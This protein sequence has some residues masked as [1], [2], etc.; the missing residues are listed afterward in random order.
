MSNLDRII[1]D[2]I[3][4]ALEAGTVPW[5]RPWVAAGGEH[6]NPSSGTVYRGVN[7]LLLELSAMEHEFA[8]ARWL[9]MRQANALGGRV[10]K[11]SRST[12]VI[13]YKKRE[14]EDA[15][16]G[17]TRER[18]VM[19]HFTVFNVDQ[20]EGIDWPAPPSFQ[21][22]PV[23]RADELVRGYVETTGP[24][25]LHGAQSRAFYNREADVVKLPATSQFPTAGGY[26]ATAFHELVHSTGHERRLARGLDGAF[27]SA[28]YAREE[29]IAEVGA[30]MLVAHC[31]LHVDYE[32]TPA[33]IA[34]WLKRLGD[35]VQLV[36]RAA[37]AAQRARDMIA[38]SVAVEAELA[39]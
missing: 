8:D 7:P 6:R 11:G 4:A 1:T 31:G 24:R 12:L 10:R 39:A 28:P 32:S 30:A 15:E 27:G 36:T 17:E 20:V 16:T 38:S 21:W 26:Y 37:A 13:F 18:R 22:D 3:I 25:L 5:R 2:K 9:T 34:S 14:V 35:D 29:L 23:E 19:R 33:Y